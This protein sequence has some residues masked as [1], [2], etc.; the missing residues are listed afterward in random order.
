MQK[1]IYFYCYAKSKSRQAGGPSKTCKR[2]KTGKEG[3]VPSKKHGSVSLANMKTGVPTERTP[4]YLT[5]TR[6]LGL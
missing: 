1:L 3:K 6:S 5:S 2:K 4:Y